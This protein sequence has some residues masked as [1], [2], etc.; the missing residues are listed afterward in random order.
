[1][2]K[3][4]KNPKGKILVAVNLDEGSG[5]LLKAAANLA[6]K[7]QSELAVLHVCD[8]WV[9]RTW[10]NDM[11][12]SG[13]VMMNLAE[14]AEA[15]ALRAARTRLSDL[16]S[17]NVKGVE[18]QSEVVLGFPDESIR[19]H[20]VTTS[21]DLL[22]LGG[23]SSD[24]RFVPS[25]LSTVISLLSEAPVPVIVIPKNWKGS[26]NT[27][28]M[29]IMIADD[30]SS[31]GEAA[32]HAGYELSVRL[33]GCSLFHTHVTQMSKEALSA[34]IDT[35]AA[36]SHTTAG[37]LNSDEI[38]AATMSSLEKKVH[39]RA[40]EYQSQLS[41]NGTRS[42][43]SI[44]HGNPSDAVLKYAADEKP[45]LLVFGRHR[46]WRRKPFVLGQLPFH[47]MLKSNLPV[48]VAG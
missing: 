9:G 36:A 32:V 7:S 17:A 42:T 8:Y 47:G 11:M 31:H 35:A 41:A 22:M 4:F 23:T 16:L 40:G 27:D 15:E 18:V 3:L 24:Y 34:A 45:D 30:L 38:W 20:A 14:S 1:M 19:A 46:T 28:R 33:G 44:L 21:A 13:S 2:T 26:W 5:P 29:R 10:A 37:A 25:G 48:M 39:S 12:L 6:E 43:V